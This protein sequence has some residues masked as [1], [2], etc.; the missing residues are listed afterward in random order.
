MDMVVRNNES[1]KDMRL[2]TPFDT[3]VMVLVVAVRL[4]YVIAPFV[5]NF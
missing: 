5:F 4:G 2:Y 1:R 3:R